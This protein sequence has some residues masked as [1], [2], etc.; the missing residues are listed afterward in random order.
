MSVDRSRSTS[1]GNVTVLAV[2]SQLTPV[3]DEVPA[4]SV[5]PMYSVKSLL[6]DDGLDH[7]QCG[8]VPRVFDGEALVV[9]RRVELSIRS[10]C[11]WRISRNPKT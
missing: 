4:N 6:P 5:C 1:P 3:P 10:S 9:T 8:F 11:V 2:V 7:P